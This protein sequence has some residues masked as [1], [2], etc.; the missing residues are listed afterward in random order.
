MLQ[1]SVSDQPPASLFSPTC[2]ETDN[3]QQ[4]VRASEAHKPQRKKGRP[5]IAPE[6]RIPN[7]VRKVNTLKHKVRRLDKKARVQKNLLGILQQKNKIP[8]A[9]L[10]SIDGCLQELVDYEMKNRCRKTNR[11]YSEKLKEFALTMYYYLPTAYLCLSSL[12]I[13]IAEC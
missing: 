11:K 3:Q 6:I 13:Q 2:S 12:S 7:L 4:A 8:S 5:K 9:K 10:S 1:E